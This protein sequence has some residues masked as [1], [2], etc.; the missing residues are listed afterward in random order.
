M[1]S[2]HPVSAVV[3]DARGSVIASERMDGAVF[4]TTDAARGKAL[5]SASLGAPS[6]SMTQ[7]ATSG[8]ADVLPGTPVMLQGALP[9]VRNKVTV[10]AVGCGGGSGQQDED[11]A[12][13]AIAALM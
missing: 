3:V 13:A 12:R 2:V 1:E 5:V 4:F 11:V 10:G 7:L 8:V 6:G 9:I